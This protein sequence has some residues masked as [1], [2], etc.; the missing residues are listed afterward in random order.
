M[1]CQWQ[2][3][4]QHYVFYSCSFSDSASLLLSS[5]FYHHPFIFFYKYYLS[6]YWKK[7]IFK[8]CI[9]TC[10]SYYLLLRYY[11]DYN[12]DD[13]AVLFYVL[14]IQ[15]ATMLSS[16]FIINSMKSESLP[17]IIIIF[18]PISIRNLVHDDITNW[19]ASCFQGIF[20]F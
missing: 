10:L 15:A 5:V 6:S 7:K 8:K 18:M 19:L 16:L 9:E 4:Q 14:R 12:Y 1:H 20:F 3:R 13:D 17:I 11:Y 2:K